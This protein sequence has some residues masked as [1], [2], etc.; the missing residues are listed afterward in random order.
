MDNEAAKASWIVGSAHSTV[1]KH[2]IHNGT[3]LEALLEVQPYF[4]R[5]PTHSNF[6]DD[7]SRGRFS[8]LES[9]GASTTMISDALI[10]KLCTW[11]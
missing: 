6:G 4:A 1:A 11:H 5:V 10:A 7:P 3:R 2:A 8:K 9:L